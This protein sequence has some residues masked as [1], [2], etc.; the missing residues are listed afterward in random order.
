MQARHRAACQKLPA[1][2]Q[3][4]LDAV[5][6]DGGVIVF[7]WLDHVL[8]LLWHLQLGQLYKLPEG[9]VALPKTQGAVGPI[10]LPVSDPKYLSPH[11]A[12][13]LCSATQTDLG[14][15]DHRVPALFV[16]CRLQPPP[17]ALLPLV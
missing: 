4:L 10:S 9:A 1:Q 17:T 11:Q 13:W 14:K 7:D 16:L 5:V 12:S 8:D 6:T 2:A 3:R 15:S